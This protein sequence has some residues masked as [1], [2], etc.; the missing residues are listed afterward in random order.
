M[1]DEEDLEQDSLDN[2]FA[3][4]SIVST[5]QSIV[6]SVAKETNRFATRTKPIPNHSDDQLLRAIKKE[7]EA[8]SMANVSLPY[9]I[10][11]KPTQ[12]LSQQQTVEED[13]Q[14]YETETFSKMRIKNRLIDQETMERRMDSRTLI[15][16]KKVGLDGLALEHRKD[17]WVVLG[18]IASKSDNR[19]SS[20]GNHYCFFRLSD[21]DGHIVNVFMY[22]D[23]FEAHWK[24]KVGSIVAV[25]NPT[26]IKPTE[27]SLFN[28]LL[29]AALL[30]VYEEIQF[31][32]T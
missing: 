23:T 4:Q 25:L 18:V 16:I 22:K 14:I 27:V 32:R 5:K 12:S 3:T 21:L 9:A 29:V 13:S 2:A 31:N 20:N 7:K 17:D 24:E 11:M 6:V 26:I 15:S 8:K 19:L 30:I 1:V 28:L 10:S